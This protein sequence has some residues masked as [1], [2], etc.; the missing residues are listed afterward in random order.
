MKRYCRCEKCDP[1]F[2]EATNAEADAMF[3]LVDANGDGV[4]DIAEFDILITDLRRACH[5]RGEDPSDSASW[6]PHAL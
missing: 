6:C 5:G 1:K 4:V 2:V 3:D